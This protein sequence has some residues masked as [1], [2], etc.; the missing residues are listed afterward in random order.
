[1]CASEAE[2]FVSRNYPRNPRVALTVSNLTTDNLGPRLAIEPTAADY[3]RDLCVHRLLADSIQSCSGALSVQFQNTCLTYAELETQSNRLARFLQK[4]GVG[5]EVLVGICVERSEQMLVALLGTLKAGGA[6]VPL[7]PAYPRDRIN[8][9]LDDAS[10]K[11]VLSQQRLL[12]SLPNTLAEVVCLDSEGKDWQREDSAPVTSSVQPDNLAYVIY[13][14]GST[15]RP[16]GVQLEHRSVMNFLCSMRQVPGMTANDVL[17]AVTTLSF[18]IAGLELY[19]PLLVGGRL[20][21]APRETTSDGR[22]LMQLMAKSRT[23][24]MQATP[25][26]WRVLLESGWKGDP[27]LKVL[28]GGEALSPDLAR[29]LAESCA[30]V[31]NMYGPT[32]TTIWS[33]AYKV[34]GKDEKLVPIGSPIANTTFH[35]LDSHRR[36]VPVGQEGELYIGGK[37][38]ARGYLERDEMTAEKF[39]AHPIGANPAVRL[40]RTGDRARFRPDGNVEFLGRI[41]QQVKIRGFRIE[42]GEI[43]AVLEQ[44]RAVSQAVVVAREDFPGDK[45]LVAYLVSDSLNAVKAAQLRAHCGT[46]LPDYMLPSAF[47]PM[48]RLPL[49]PSGKVDRMALPVPAASDFGSDT[50]YVAPRDRVERRLVALW[51]VVLDIKP[52]SVTANFFELGGISVLAA[53]LFTKILRTFAKEL[54]LSTLFRSPTVEQLANELRPSGQEAEYRTVV[55]IQEG[56]AR[57]PFFCVHGGAG[58]TLFLHQLARELGPVQPFYGVEPDGLDGKPFRYQTVEE[59]ARYYLSEIRKVQPTGPYYLG[60]YCFGGLV[61]FEMARILQRQGEPPALVA[62]FS[63]AL[64]FHHGKSRQAVQ[65]PRKSIDSRTGKALSSPIRTARNLATALYWCAVQKF[66]KYS[67]RLVFSLGLRVPPEMRTMYVMQMLTWAEEKFQPQPYA[68]SLVL[69]YGE[70][71][72]DF[73]ANLGWDG[74]A[75]DFEQC[76]IGDGMLDSRRDIMN[77]PLAGT[78]AKKLAPYLNGTQWNASRAAFVIDANRGIQ[79]GTDDDCS[80]QELGSHPSSGR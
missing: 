74:L 40:Y 67:Y 80:R 68:G 17:V 15:G 9:V 60:G 58:S 25:T 24:I 45:R 73:G 14:S 75:E 13:T 2:K 79:Y 33:S 19:L 37:G 59:M 22:L 42:L 55:P 28:V 41:D 4:K 34:D 7:D 1:M 62:L 53:Q 31:W 64:R 32:E 3:P 21:V 36:P 46:K 72:L 11:L 18:D 6:Y 56:G 69:F 49:S 35:I 44:H 5:P 30:S 38:L 66:R 61:A 71:T 48:E 29:Q 77:E 70:G 16:K 20:V 54:P 65:R 78:T 57:A 10:I 27:N 63:A 8:Y 26:T 76:V 39:V 12:A 52:I 23:T 43:E 47:V 50:T 51:Q